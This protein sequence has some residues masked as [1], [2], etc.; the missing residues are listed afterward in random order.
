MTKRGKKVQIERIYKP[1]VQ[2]QLH[3]LLLLLRLRLPPEGS[4]SDHIQE[5]RAINQD[6][7]ATTGRQTN[8]DEQRQIEEALL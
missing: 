1:D 8:E 5:D 7:T 6:S 2:Y 3:A 4:S